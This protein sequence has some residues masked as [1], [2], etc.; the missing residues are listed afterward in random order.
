MKFYNY[1]N[2]ITINISKEDDIEIEDF[3]NKTSILD[4]AQKVIDK[5]NSDLFLTKKKSRFK[6]TCTTTPPNLKN[7]DKDKVINK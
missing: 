4:E 5:L 2:N 3:L 6:L 1:I 7:I